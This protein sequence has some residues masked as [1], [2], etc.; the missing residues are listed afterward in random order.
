MPGT[1][2]SQPRRNS[3]CDLVVGDVMRDHRSRTN[4][5]AFSNRHSSGNDFPASN[6]CSAHH[7]SRDDSPILFRLQSPVGRGARI[8]IV[9]EHH[10]VPNEDVVFDVH[11]FADKT[12]RGDLAAASNEDVFLD[13]DEGA[14]FGLVTQRASVEV[15]QIWLED[16]YILPKNNVGGNSH[17]SYRVRRQ[18]Q[19]TR[20]DTQIQT[21]EKGAR[22]TI[23]QNS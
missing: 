9:D 7:A 20:A 8:Q 11:S 4:Q 2:A 17:E 15:H 18:K 3:F 21:S 10:A 5:S 14:D 19:E 12:V 23:Q 22:R 13:L 1:R 6:R 16:S